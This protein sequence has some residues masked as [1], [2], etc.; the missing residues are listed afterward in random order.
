M[1]ILIKLAA[2]AALATALTANAW[3]DENGEPAITASRALSIGEVY[4]L[5]PAVL[6]APRHIVIRT[7]TGYD[8]A[9]DKT[10][11][12]LYVIDGGAEQ[13]F[14]HIA[15]LVQSA[16]INATFEPMIVVGVETMNRRAEISPPVKDA[17]LYEEELG[18]TPGGSMKFREFLATDVKPFVDE[19]FRTNGHD[20][21]MGESL[22]GLFVVETL[23]KAPDMFDDYISVSPSM[24]WEN[25]EYAKEA[26]DYLDALPGG[27][28]R[29]YLTLA[30]EGY[31]HGEG[32]E[33][34]VAALERSAPDTLQWLFVPLGQ[35]EN[36]ASIYHVAAL[37]AL[38][39]F[40][41]LPT[42]YGRPGKLL[43]GEPLGERTP[44]Q[45][46]RLDTPCTKETAR[47]TTPGEEAANKNAK[48]YECLLFDFGP[49]ASAGT[50]E[51]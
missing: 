35:S 23:F 16:E 49:R 2:F 42:Q 51:R 38:R 10:Y 37:D 33:K 43:S 14:P 15:G 4:T 31:R 44:E 3:A 5:P 36:H 9:A 30:D 21:L 8:E 40:Y 32:V 28:K 12:V 20:A 29:L 45:Q 47:L 17:T 25:M 34:L 19:H 24:W 11:P 50:F 18:A 27:E 41:A 6:G 26:S 7:P 39:S 13:D 48:V 46:K 22:A 1:R